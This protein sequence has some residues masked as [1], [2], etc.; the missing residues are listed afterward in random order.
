MAVTKRLQRQ[1]FV[2]HIMFDKSAHF[3][4]VHEETTVC[5]DIPVFLLIGD[6]DD[7]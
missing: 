1:V 6:Y 2:T 7:F 5:V 3:G 4:V